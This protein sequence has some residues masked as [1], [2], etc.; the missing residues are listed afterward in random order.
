MVFIGE[1]RWKN[2]FLSQTPCFSTRHKVGQILGGNPVGSRPPATATT[3]DLLSNIKR[4]RS[5]HHVIRSLKKK[6]LA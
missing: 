3:C 2:S 6:A 1:D 4:K 5:R